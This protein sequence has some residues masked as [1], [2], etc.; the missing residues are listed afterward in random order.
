MKDFFLRFIDENMI[1]IEDGPY[2]EH[3]KI[4][5]RI[6]TQKE[7]NDILRMVYSLGNSESQQELKFKLIDKIN[8]I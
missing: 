5:V 6:Y 1:K 8:Q 2:N 7:I 3:Y 4:E